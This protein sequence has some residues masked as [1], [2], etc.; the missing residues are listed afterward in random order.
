MPRKN[1]R[2]IYS[3]NGDAYYVSPS[4]IGASELNVTT[5]EVFVTADPD[6]V[7]RGRAKKWF[8]EFNMNP[9]D[10]T[11]VSNGKPQNQ[12]L[13]DK[14]ERG[15]SQAA[16]WMR[17]N[18]GLNLLGMG[19]GAIP[20][21]VA[22][23]PLAANMP[24]F[25]SIMAGGR[26]IFT[27]GSNFWTNPVTGNV[28]RSM[29]KGTTANAILKLTT[30]KTYGEGMSSIINNVTGLNPAN[31][32]LGQFAVDMT[33]PFYYGTNE[34]AS[35][36]NKIGD[37]V[38]S[39]DKNAV[40]KNI[41]KTINN[42]RGFLYDFIGDGIRDKRIRVNRL[43]NRAFENI[44]NYYTDKYRKIN[45]L[46]SKVTKMSYNAFL[47][48]HPQLI[49]E[50]LLPSY[51][52]VQR[53]NGV[54]FNKMSKEDIINFFKNKTSVDAEK[55]FDDAT[56]NFVDDIEHTSLPYNPTKAV[57]TGKTEVKD[58]KT[59]ETE[60][61]D[62]NSDI[63]L[64]SA[65]RSVFR[66]IYEPVTDTRDIKLISK[67]TG[68][69]TEITPSVPER[70]REMLEKNINTV[71]N[72]ILPGSKA[73]GSTTN[74]VK[75]N[76]YHASHDYDVIMTEAQAKAHPDFSKF[77]S[78]RGNDTYGYMH[79]SAGEL[80]V[81]VIRENN[82]KAVGSI[83][84]EL[85]AQM[86]PKEYKNLMMEA[87]KKGITLDT[88][89][90]L[91][92]TAQELLDA[93]DPVT[94]GIL[95]AF[96]SSKD[97]HAARAYYYL[98]YG[99]VNDVRKGFDAYANYILGG[100]Y[101]PNNIPLSEFSNAEANSKFI[102]ELGLKGINKSQFINNPQR[103]K[104][105][106]DYYVYDKTFVGR[107]VPFTYNGNRVDPIKALTFWEPNTTGGT[108]NGVGLNTVIGGDSGHGDIYA[109]IVPS[110]MKELQIN[111]PQ[112]VD[113][114]I[115]KNIVTRDLTD[116]EIKSIGEIAK[117]N[118]I[119]IYQTGN[120]LTLQDVLGQTSGATGENY[121]TFIKELGET[122][123][124][125]FIKGRWDYGSAPYASLLEDQSPDAIKQFFVHGADRPQP[126][127]ARE[128]IAGNSMEESFDVRD[129]SP[130]LNELE[131]VV[132]NRRIRSSGRRE[133][134]KA[135]IS[136][137]D[138][139]IGRVNKLREILAY[140]K[141]KLGKE[142][143]F[144]K[145]NSMYNHA[146][147]LNKIEQN[148]EKYRT[149]LRNIKATILAGGSTLTGGYMINAAKKHGEEHKKRM[150]ERKAK[151]HR[152]AYSD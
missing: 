120:Y 84:H 45:S 60:N 107:G 42:V 17:E 95:D 36:F 134:V 75:G 118:N 70:Y 124:L 53:L 54:N 56:G 82:G 39:I 152:L 122:L 94:K 83:A 19:L 29:A 8:E 140:K 108:A 117:R 51:L 49:D 137:Q 148:I 147:A 2:L 34:L 121:K 81:N 139:T 68:N 99:N 4:A 79:P 128:Q 33:D 102:D 80:D 25:N 92:K 127:K 67:T 149:R 69:P 38:S 106:F 26:N 63:F 77:Y 132:V 104:L 151:R 73:F 87:A 13:E 15:A 96:A 125:P 30:G 20:L 114:Q 105:L 10:E 64:D 93:Y 41:S 123:D 3:G 16:S 6:D 31:S 35:G 150:A 72:E 116:D 143:D 133:A 129:Y 55:Y 112:D 40:K 76:L 89:V 1:R 130:N 37:I 144:R 58:I 32:V 91:D 28:M 115:S 65:D 43:H 18:Q 142:E 47:D 100:D 146:Y 88:N 78:K 57:K 126:V 131:D 27:P 111:T 101:R 5:P 98:N 46:A 23:Y 85:Y 145:N 103:M 86:Y 71:T 109:S 90:E 24:S 22:L 48:K 11:I 138:Y 21:G 136:K 119:P 14:A 52:K 59:G 50:N 74:I 113:A 97:K 110:R 7:A 135:K 61:F 12:Y 9:N 62:L 66:H 141:A 44:H